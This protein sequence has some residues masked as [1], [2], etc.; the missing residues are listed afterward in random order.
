M[1]VE[2]MIDL[3]RERIVRADY[4]LHQQFRYEYPG[5]IEHLRHR[6]VVAPP[7]V[8][9]DQIRVD[10]RLTASPGLRVRWENDAFGNRVAT[11]HAPRV[12]R[13][14]RFDYEATIRR[15]DGPAPPLEASWFA[16][17]RF[18]Q[19]SRLTYPS[20]ALRDAAEA[21]IAA[22]D[23]S[24]RLANRINSFVAQHMRYVPDATS[25]ETTAAEAFAQGAGV[26]QDYA[27]V[28]IALCRLCGIPARYVSGHLLGEGGTHAWLEVI[29]P[30][31]G[32]GTPRIAGYDPTHDRRTTLKYVFVAAGRDYTDVA[33]TSG[34]FVAPY[35]GRFTTT[36][37]V[38]VVDVEYA[39]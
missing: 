21:L 20:L 6:L 7:R 38:D 10:H 36:R 35:R 11:V 5:P 16:D 29:E 13:E 32:T 30:A 27:H 33:P 9:G 22:D 17:A 1:N 37:R 31:P 39:A 19:P 3:G 15:S 4:V 26:C 8:Y 14:V 28:M 34:Q 24:G 2:R 25:V 18:R 23:G 12:E